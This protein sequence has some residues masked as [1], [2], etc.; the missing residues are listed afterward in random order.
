MRFKTARGRLGCI[1]EY[2]QNASLGRS[3]CVTFFLIK[4]RMAEKCFRAQLKFTKKEMNF[5]A[6]VCNI[7][8]GGS[9]IA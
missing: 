6:N 7:K 4:C 3:R 2:R 5:S 8:T 9:S 1:N